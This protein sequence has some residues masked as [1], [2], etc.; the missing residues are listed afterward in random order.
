MHRESTQWRLLWSKTNRLMERM[1]NGVRLWDFEG[2][3]LN[4]LPKVKAKPLPFLGY[5]THTHTHT[6]RQI[7]WTRQVA[8]CCAYSVTS[9]RSCNQRCR[10]QAVKLNSV[11]LVRERTIPTVRPPPVGEDSANFCG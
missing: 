10:G 7:N 3:Q 1:V 8:M 9:R 5:Y 6:I 2:Q 4:D 11:A